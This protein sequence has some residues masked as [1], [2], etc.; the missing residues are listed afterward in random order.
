MNEDRLIALE[1]KIAHLEFANERMEKSIFDQSQ[2]IAQ[3]E[4]MVKWLKDR[5]DESGVGNAVPPNEKP[6]HY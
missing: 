2:Q 4:K 6:P 3:L 1:T 5:L